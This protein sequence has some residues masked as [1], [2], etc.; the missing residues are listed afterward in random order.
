MRVVLI[1]PNSTAAMTRSA[2]DAARQA[3]P[4]LTI[5]GWTSDKGPVAIQ[6]VEDGA[7]AVPPLLELV[8][9]ASGDG[10]DA[11][12]IAC[13]DDTGLAQA[14]ARARCP[15][16][17]IGQASFIMAELRG[18]PSAV[19]TTVPEAVPII[20]ANVREQGHAGRI[21][22]VLAADVPVLML[23]EDPER[24][25]DAFE[26]AARTLPTGIAN[27]IIGCAG[28]VTITSILEQ[29][30]AMPVMDGVTSA[31]R[32]CRALSG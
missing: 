6:G 11:I 1:N 27:L 4:D 9:T 15:V 23:E 7:R 18:G 20:A 24:A 13:F 32:L 3:A 22:H 19:I 17:G 5:E 14:Q 26:A 21:A 8:D 16:I 25:A 30:L 29:R 10:A 2:L 28:A 12:I 31:A